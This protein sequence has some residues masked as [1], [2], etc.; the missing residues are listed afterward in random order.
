MTF[1]Y[2][3]GLWKYSNDYNG[4]VRSA[5]AKYD[6]IIVDQYWAESGH[7]VED[8]DEQWGNMMIIS[9]AS[10]MYEAIKEHLANGS[11]ENTDNLFKSLIE[12][13][14]ES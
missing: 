7:G 2:T 13:I 1:K 3:K 9:N 11:N 14:E 5:E 4:S 8:D 6:Y 10:L 12:R